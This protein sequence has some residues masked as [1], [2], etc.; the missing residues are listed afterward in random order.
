M[1]RLA[2]TIGAQGKAVDTI[3]AAYFEH[4]LDIGDPE[5]L[6][7]LAEEIG[8]DRQVATTHMLSEGDL[9]SVFNE[10]ARMH[11]L[12]VT[13]VPCYIFNENKA[14]SGAQEPEIIVRMLDMAAAK[15]AD[16]PV[17]QSTG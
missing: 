1:V 10:N 14:I 9:N 2:Q 3:F 12:G 5:V 11:R 7:R 6:I 15:E 8:L 13:G 17:L 16:D 4:G